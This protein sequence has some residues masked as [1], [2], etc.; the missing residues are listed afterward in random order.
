MAIYLGSQY[1]VNLSEAL[2]G[3]ILDRVLEDGEE[4]SHVY[5]DADDR[6]C[7]KWGEVMKLATWV[8]EEDS[9]DFQEFFH[10]TCVG[11][12]K[13]HDTGGVNIWCD[14]QWSYGWI[15]PIDGY[16]FPAGYEE[17]PDDLQIDASD[18][19]LWVNGE[20]YEVPKGLDLEKVQE[21][22]Q[23]GRDLVEEIT[24][25][26]CAEVDEYINDKASKIA[27]KGIE[28]AEWSSTN[29]APSPFE[30]EEHL[31]WQYNGEDAGHYDEIV[32]LSRNWQRTVQGTWEQHNVSEYTLEAH[33]INW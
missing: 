20:G 18:G 22:V 27:K 12:E 29:D 6:F 28:L 16:Q 19:L 4:I 8:G 14:T 3:I 7:E 13:S 23:S 26:I 1:T 31:G 2:A 11:F 5:M 32:V 17:H 24:E 30:Y 25:W 10:D 33:G 15:V 9:P 21:M